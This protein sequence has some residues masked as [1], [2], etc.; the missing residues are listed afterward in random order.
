M[1]RNPELQLVREGRSDLYE[2]YEMHFNDNICEFTEKVVALK[3]RVA[4]QP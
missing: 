3:R 2:H 4:E 1:Q